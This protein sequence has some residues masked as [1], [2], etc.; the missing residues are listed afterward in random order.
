MW[1]HART[2][3]YGTQGFCLP[4][5]THTAW[6]NPCYG[7]QALS[8]G[9]TCC[10]RLLQT[11]E[12]QEVTFLT[13][14][15]VKFEPGSHAQKA[16]ILTT[17]LYLCTRLMLPSASWLHPTQTLGHDDFWLCASTTT[18][19][20]QGFCLPDFTHKAWVKPWYGFSDKSPDGAFGTRVSWSESEC[21]NHSA[22]NLIC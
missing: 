22:T 10:D 4:D 16:S 21:S 12:H 17:W 18:D 3:I 5:F 14:I 20:P 11:E 15:M 7:L 8:K 6:V 19:S 2:A 1:L 9:A 13:S